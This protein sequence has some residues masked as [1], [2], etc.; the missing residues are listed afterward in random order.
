[1][2]YQ[3]SYTPKSMRYRRPLRGFL[4]KLP[5]RQFQGGALYSRSAGRIKL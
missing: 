2:L 1:V 3:L 4:P 5:P